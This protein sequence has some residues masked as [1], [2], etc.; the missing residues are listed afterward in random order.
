MFRLGSLDGAGRFLTSLHSL[1]R[2]TMV[3][4]AD[5]HG[6]ARPHAGECV[7]R[8]GR[9]TVVFECLAGGIRLGEGFAGCFDNVL[10]DAGQ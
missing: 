8:G 6:V 7:E 3:S 2:S 5:V 4:R 10:G 1:A 9:G